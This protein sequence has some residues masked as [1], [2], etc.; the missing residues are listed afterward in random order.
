MRKKQ[1][2]Y[3]A[4][5]LNVS[6]AFANELVGGSFAGASVWMYVLTEMSLAETKAVWSEG[7]VAAS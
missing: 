2:S 5:I 4:I 7:E 3:L 1:T 6:A